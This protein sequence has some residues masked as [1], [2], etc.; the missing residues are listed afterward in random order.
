MKKLSLTNQQKQTLINNT[1]FLD[2]FYTKI[3]L[4]QRWWHNENQESNLLMCLTCNKHPRR[5]DIAQ[6]TYGRFCSSKCAHNHKSVKNKTKDTCLK[7]YGAISNLS[8]KT[9]QEITKQRLLEKYGV[10]HPARSLQIQQKT[11]K[12]LMSKYGVS[13]APLSAQAKAK[14]Q[15]TNLE[16]YGVKHHWASDEIK[17]KVKQT[18]L[19][20]YGVENPSQSNLIQQKKSKLLYEKKGIYNISQCN[21][22]DQAK[23]VLFDIDQFENFAKNHSL[24]SM[25]QTLQVDR[26]TIMNYAIKYNLAQLFDTSSYLENEMCSFLDSMNIHYKKNC[27]RT[28]KGLELDFYLPEY[29]LGIECNGDYWHSDRFRDSNYHQNKWKICQEHNIQLI[30]IGESDWNV[31]NQ[32]IKMMICSRLGLKEKGDPGRKCNIQPITTAHAKPF[33]DQY[34][35]QGFVSGSSYWG[36]YDTLN[37]LVAVMVFGWTRGSKKSR[38]FELKRWA[39]DNYSHAGLFSKVF[40]HAQKELGFDNIVSFSMNDWFSGN[41]Y[42]SSGFSQGNITRPG[43]FYVFNGKKYHPS[44]FTKSRIV[45]MFPEFYSTEKTERQLM[46]EIGAHRIWDSGKIEWIWKLN[47]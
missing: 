17:Q 37:N 14:T 1:S 42:E 22:S 4:R 46:R 27:R 20:R 21:Y 6:K 38:R 16:R 43:Y 24:I 9:G 25:S 26:T 30:Q 3:P 8:S 32:Q 33:L 23:G 31:R 41:V 36:A 28:I 45:K 11:Q 10:D 7:R 13:A 35:L 44:H 5:W 47:H 19:A 40:K 39:T 2:E 18:N 34:H 29:S 12:T 15:Q